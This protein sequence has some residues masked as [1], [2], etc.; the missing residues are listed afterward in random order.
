MMLIEKIAASRYHMGKQNKKMKKQ[1]KW[2]DKKDNDG[3]IDL[4]GQSRRGH[5]GKG[6]GFGERMGENTGGI[7][8][9]DQGGGYRPGTGWSNG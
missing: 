4:D 3:N 2:L 5:S 1:R 9:T 6:G 7:T 8:Y